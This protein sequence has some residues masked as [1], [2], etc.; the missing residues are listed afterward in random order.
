MKYLPC[1]HTPDTCDS[2]ALKQAEAHIERLE[3]AVR[4]EVET[5]LWNVCGYEAFG[6]NDIPAV[7]RRL[8]AALSTDNQSTEDK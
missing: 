5:G 2:C 1:E 6:D 3:K 4:Y 8:K 7:C